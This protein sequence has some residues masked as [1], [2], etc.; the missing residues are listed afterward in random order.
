MQ[1][2]ATD[3]THNLH[4]HPCLPA[5]LV[6][7]QSLMRLTCLQVP[8]PELPAPTA[9]IWLDMAKLVSERDRGRPGLYPRLLL[10]IWACT[11]WTC[12]ERMSSVLCCNMSAVSNPAARSTEGTCRTMWR[13]FVPQRQPL[14]PPF[15]LYNCCSSG[16]SA[17][18][19]RDGPQQQHQ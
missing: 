16:C 9:Q 2:S 11:R 5:N 3:A 18:N 1:L 12:A 6:Y 4:A 13:P 19:R 8:G 15:P 14:Q 10:Q 17:L 7:C